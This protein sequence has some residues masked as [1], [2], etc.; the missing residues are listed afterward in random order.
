MADEFDSEGNIISL[1]AAPAPVVSQPI[2]ILDKT[3]VPAQS[4]HPTPPL[5][6]LVRKP[7][8]NTTE[9]SDDRPVWKQRALPGTKPCETYGFITPKLNVFIQNI[10][11]RE[12]KEMKQSFD[13]KYHRLEDNLRGK[14]K[15]SCSDKTQIPADHEPPISV[16]SGSATASAVT[17]NDN[18]S[19]NISAIDSLASSWTNLLA[20][21]RSENIKLLRIRINCLNQ[22]LLK[23]KS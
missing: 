2:A 1:K 3:T 23:L 7:S 4:P 16:E 20:K 13:K 18:A 17:G 10:L 19:K 6:S 11:A 21:L 15:C 22:K 9:V 12:R 14:L 5:A 8:V